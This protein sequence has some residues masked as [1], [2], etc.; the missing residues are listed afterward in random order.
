MSTGGL[1]LLLGTQ[2]F[3]FHGLPQIELAVYILDLV[4]FTMICSLMVTRFIV[5]GG[6]LDSIRHPRE[7]FW[8]MQLKFEYDI[9]QCVTYSIVQVSPR[10]VS[11]YRP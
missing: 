9:L 5:H 7:G 4:L 8:C 11:S 1:A 10:N 2:L 3:Q 6:T